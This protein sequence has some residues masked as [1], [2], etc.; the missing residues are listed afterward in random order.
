MFPVVA[1]SAEL[2]AQ[3]EVALPSARLRY[4]ERGRGAPVLFV[5]G[6]LVNGDL[7]R[8]VVPGLA[9]AG[10]RCLTPDW[11]LG[12]HELP[13]PDADLRPPGLAALIADF[14][15]ALDLT[16]V[17]VVAND[18]GGALTQLLM[19]DHPD[20][21]GR[22]VLISCDC[23]ER[24][25]PQPFAPLP[26]L[27]RVPGVTWGMVQSMRW[28]ALQRLPIAFGWAAKR[29]LPAPI[30][31]SYL[32]PSRDDPA[33]RADLRRFVAGVHR[34]YTLDA[35][36]RLGSFDRDVLLVWARQDRLFPVALAHRLA[37]VLP[38]A[39]LELVADSYTFVPEDQPAEL[40]RLLLTFLAARTAR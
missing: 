32:R 36:T 35:A 12:S 38:R 10:Y 1:H 27:V 39:T 16:D 21:V 24:F 28:R 11:P 29:P 18:T 14:L 22:V 37:A 4:R 23:F 20:R 8:G 40:T 34:R 3:H 15:T 19:T 25:F 26:R 33:V 2:G 5:H 6:L 13:V 30:A 7:W 17:T 9:E 31:D